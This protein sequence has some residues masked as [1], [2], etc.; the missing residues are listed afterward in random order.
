[1]AVKISLCSFGLRSFFGLCVVALLQT[2]A[3]AQTYEQLRLKARIEKRIAAGETQV[4]QFEAQ[5]KHY[6]RFAVGRS[7]AHI[8]FFI[9]ESSG[10][11][12]ATLN[13]LR[14][15]SVWLSFLPSTTGK[16]TLIVRSEEK[17]E[18]AGRYTIALQEDRLA[19]ASDQKRLLAEQAFSEGEGLRAAWNAAALQKALAQYRTAWL[20]WQAVDDRSG[21]SRAMR[22]LGD[23]YRSIG[24]LAKAQKSYTEAYNLAGD[25]VRLK[26]EALIGLSSASTILGSHQKA[27]DYG[28]EARALSRQLGDPAGEARALFCIGEAHFFKDGQGSSYSEEALTTVLEI[29]D[30]AGQ[31]TAYLE[32]SYPMGQLPQQ[33]AQALEYKEKSL[34][35]WRRLGDKRGQTTAL[36]ALG[37]FSSFIDNNQQ[38]LAY[39]HEAEPLVIGCGE[40]EMEAKLY[41]GLAFLHEGFGDQALALQYYLKALSKWRAAK[42][43]TAEVEDLTQVAR[44]YHEM[45]KNRLALNYLLEAKKLA[46]TIK[47]SPSEAWVYAHMG[48]VYS[49]I[50]REKDALTAYQGALKESKN[51]IAWIRALALNGIGKICY[52]RGDYQTASSWY[53]KAL[54]VNRNIQGS[55][56]EISTLNNIAQAERGSGNL[57]AALQ[58]LTQ[59]IQKIEVL[60][61][62]LMEPSHRASY[63]AT[64]RDAYQLTIDT[65]MQL[66][67]RTQNHDFII[68]AFEVSE[69]ARARS[70]LDILKESKTDIT[71]ATDPA[72]LEE[73]RNLLSQITEK[74]RT[75][76]QLYANASLKA[77]TVALEQELAELDVRR[78]YV[79]SLIRSANPRYAALTQPEPSKL[80]EIQQL[81]D[82]E[83]ILLEYS[84]GDEKSYLWATTADSIS[85]FQLPSQADIEKIARQVY[86]LLIA[87][88]KLVKGESDHLRE[89][90]CAQAEAEYPQAALRLSQMILAP[91]ISRLGTKRLIIVADGA[92]Q[93]IP[94]AALPDLKTEG[95]KSGTL[96]IKDFHPLIKEHEIINLPSASALSAIRRELE[97]R[98]P[99]AKTV[100]VIADPVFNKDDAKLRLAEIRQA[101]GN[102]T[103]AQTNALQIAVRQMQIEG[104]NIAID[105]LPFSHEEAM[106]ILSIAPQ[107]ESLALLNFQA[108]KQTVINTDLSQYRFIHFATHGLL[109]SNHPELSKLILS[110]VDKEGK[111][112]DGLLQLHEIY[113]LKL[114]AELVVLSACQ[115]ALGK[116]IKGEGLVGLTRGF[117]Y[118]GASRV[119]ASL[120]NVNDA[121]TA[122]LMSHFYRYMLQEKQR[123]AE[124]LRNAQLKMLQQKKWKSPYYWAA[125]TI[126][127]EWK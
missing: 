18:V 118:A 51:A 11:Q 103:K 37:F 56:G 110:L 107:A 112:Q 98:K 67:Q 102:Q 42:L 1:M 89:I 90:R 47:N 7:T 77:Q 119:V 53:N 99:A 43:R 94:F 82:A 22:A 123:P 106:A 21:Q 68:R 3:E 75:L 96:S 70:L 13:C 36:L 105:R 61:T 59:A 29:D 124:A 41:D 78:K 10:R 122:D 115:T 92:L 39:Y 104:N 84:L 14:S 71:F 5:S 101:N 33:Q 87:P 2:P 109:D 49:T 97:S 111:S 100:A 4:Y 26:A 60:R 28:L 50:G 15:E 8:I 24:E 114:P 32:V 23:I 74:N 88:N 45:G 125:F 48:E 46:Q 80:K 54:V 64:T 95:S 81:L 16:Y 20:S 69:S 116:E 73:R 58:T 25:N 63:F 19:I 113:K 38:A 55:I 35:I 79:E 62:N 6:V 30:L 108:N 31:A 40:S 17:N 34:K 91:V 27:I 12:V 117:M 93:Y 76:A 52:R 44:L 120:W 83:T 85:S 66:S 9:S 127:G 57:D 65:L 72:L 126:Q 121:A 86:E